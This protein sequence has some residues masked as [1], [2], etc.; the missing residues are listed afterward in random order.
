MFYRRLVM[1]FLTVIFLLPIFLSAEPAFACSGGRNNTLLEAIDSASVIVKSQAVK[2][3]ESGINGIIRVEKYLLG[4]NGAEHLLL[5]QTS[6]AF[7]DDRAVRY[8]SG[9]CALPGPKLVMGE[10]VYLLLNRNEDGTYRPSIAYGNNTAYMSLRFP[11]FTPE[12]MKSVLGYVVT[13]DE[14]VDFVAE[15]KGQKASFPDKNTFYPQLAPVLI[16]T[17]EG[18]HYLLP[19]DGT[20]PIQLQ[21]DDLAYI[22]RSVPSTS[23]TYFEAFGCVE[24]GCSRASSNELDYARLTDKVTSFVYQEI[25]RPG[26]AFLFSPTNELLAVWNS[27]R[28]DFYP[29][30]YTVYGLELA[31][32]QSNVP[33]YSLPINVRDIDIRTFAKE[34]VW[35]P[36]GRMMAFTDAE[37]LWLLDIY[38]HKPEPRLLIA[39]SEVQ[40][41]ARYFSPQ[42]TY[43]AITNG[44]E[45]YHLHLLTGEKLPDGIISPTDRYLFAYDTSA[46]IFDVQLCDLTPYQC[47]E[48]RS[49]VRQVEWAN[50]T[51]YLIMNCT[52]EITSCAVEYNTL[53]LGRVM[54]DIPGFNFVYEPNTDTLVTQTGAKTII[55]GEE[56]DLGEALES[57]IKK[58][59]ILKPLWY[60]EP[61]Q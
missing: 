37:G 27:D 31:D 20:S 6:P 4:G 12:D 5:L 49:N 15:Y 53:N 51:A 41:Y 33:L 46:E 2:V 8:S 59:E 29:M 48:F 13:E 54:G 1:L 18:K 52:G 40:S 16:E 34:T 21:P 42:S 50:S 22:T 11:F 39:A 60:F 45:R 35:S 9:G 24:A 30:Y 61:A 10:S 28:I 44:D 17:Q 43:L 3:D 23:P 58:I 36:N 32:A 57:D 25:H 19:V 7:L 55:Y 14:F 47:Y 26:Q 56:L 38:A